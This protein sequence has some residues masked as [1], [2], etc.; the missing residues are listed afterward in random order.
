MKFT[1]VGVLPSSGDTLR[2]RRDTVNKQVF[3]TLDYQGNKLSAPYA[4]AYREFFEQH[5]KPQYYEDNW[6]IDCD[7]LGALFTWNPEAWTAAP[8]TPSIIFRSMA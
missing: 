6:A 5:I 1:E 2:L 4:S 7:A 8:P 3:I